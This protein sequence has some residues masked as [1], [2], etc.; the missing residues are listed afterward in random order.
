MLRRRIRV[1]LEGGLGLDR[2]RVVPGMVG[3]MRSL[4]VLVLALGM[5][6]GESGGEGMGGVGAPWREGAGAIRRGSGDIVD[7][8]MGVIVTV[9]VIVSVIIGVIGG[10]DLG[11]AIGEGGHNQGAEIEASTGDIDLIVA[12]HRIVEGSIDLTEGRGTQITI[13]D[14]DCSSHHD[15]ELGRF[16]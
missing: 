10:Q 9:T 8:G 1:R 7:I 14:A 5:I 15:K 12:T 6:M 2:I 16:G 11:M 4:M 3:R 13:T